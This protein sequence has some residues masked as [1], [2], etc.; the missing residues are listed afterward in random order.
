MDSVI[1]TKFSDSKGT[2]QNND[3]FSNLGI[4]TVQPQVMLGSTERLK[5]EKTEARQHR[6]LGTWQGEEPA[7]KK[8]SPDSPMEL[9]PDLSLVALHGL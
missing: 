5:D 4:T 2:N 9:E 8:A 7:L 3:H 6:D 1:I